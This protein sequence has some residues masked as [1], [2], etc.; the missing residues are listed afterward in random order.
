MNIMTIM[1]LKNEVPTPPTLWLSADIHWI[2][3]SYKIIMMVSVGLAEHF[4]RW[5]GVSFLNLAYSGR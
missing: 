5:G 3:E 1:S 2:A 4:K